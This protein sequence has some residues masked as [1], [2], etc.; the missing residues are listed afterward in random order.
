[1]ER[2]E[3]KGRIEGRL[4]ERQESLIKNIL[5]F[6]SEK[7][8]DLNFISNLLDVDKSTVEIILTENGIP[9]N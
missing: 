2:G 3:Q 5:K 8:L 7:G 4:E 9:V 1:M 6:Y